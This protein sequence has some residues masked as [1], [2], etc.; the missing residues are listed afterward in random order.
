MRISSLRICSKVKYKIQQIL[1]QIA[2]F[3]IVSIVT[4]DENITVSANGQAALATHGR[5]ARQAAITHRSRARDVTL[6]PRH[7]RRQNKN[8]AYS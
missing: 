8:T 6:L 1:S 3:R 7:A 4:A 2:Y 5:W